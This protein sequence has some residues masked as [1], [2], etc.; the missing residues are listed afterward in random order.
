MLGAALTRRLVREGYRI[1]A[2]A[3]PGSERLDNIPAAGG[4]VRVECDL[5]ELSG[6]KNLIHEKCDMFFHFGWNGTFGAARNDL[7]AQTD[8]IKYTLDAVN[9]A[10]DLGCEVFLGAGSQAE[11]GRHDEKVAPD[12]PTKPE[13]G[14]GI[15][16]LCAGQ[17]SRLLCEGLGIKHVWCRIISTYGPKDGEK[18]MV[19]ST[20]RKLLRGERPSCTKGEQMWDYLY[21]DDAAE[22]FYL[23][24][25]NGKN[26]VVY[27]VGSGA[28]RPLKEYIET[29]RDIVSPGTEIGFGEV[30]YAEKQVMYLCADIEPLKR[31]T[32]FEPKVSFEDGIKKTAV[33]IRAENLI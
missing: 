27:C 5:S 16:K 28:A 13:N 18:T 7:N 9:A 22:A 1:Y 21:C 23:A 10:K 31:D 26:G 6:L 4:V 30:P 24:A 3:R 33:W 15:A 29:M 12:T 19:S 14:Y 32:G 11:Y 20:M 25:K 17:M 2:V 8:N